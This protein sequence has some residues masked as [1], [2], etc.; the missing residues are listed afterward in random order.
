LALLLPEIRD[1]YCVAPTVGDEFVGKGHSTAITFP[2]QHA[3]LIFEAARGQRREGRG[4]RLDTE[5]GHRFFL[6]R[7]PESREDML[8]AV[9]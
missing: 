2:A 3:A 4:V 9:A 5:W 7:R 1:D 6:P 8:A